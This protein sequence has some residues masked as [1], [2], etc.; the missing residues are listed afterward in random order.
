MII[1]SFFAFPYNVFLFRQFFMTIPKSLDESAMIDGCNRWQIFI[2][3]VIP[4]AKPAFITIG[5]LSSVF[6][7]NELFLPLIYVQD[8]AWRPL[9][10]GALAGFRVQGAPHLVQWNLQMAMAMLMAIPPML[11][12]LVASRYLTQGI[13]ATGIKE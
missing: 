3:I 13:K 9:T 5:V 1:P 8:H 6:W 4:L 7:W 2:K 11:L 10:T 12:Y